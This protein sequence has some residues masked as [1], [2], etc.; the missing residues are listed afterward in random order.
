MLTDR[1]K[2]ETGVDDHS[3]ERE[4]HDDQGQTRCF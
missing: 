2:D 4:G 3:L 1:V